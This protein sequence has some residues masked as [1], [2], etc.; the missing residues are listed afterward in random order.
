MITTP[1]AQAK[2]SQKMARVLEM[3]NL[4]VFDTETTGT[5][6]DAQVIEIA[7]VDRFGTTMFDSLVKPTIPVPE[8]ATAIHGI[9]NE[10]LNDAP[11]LPKVEKR[12]RRLFTGKL[13][14]AYNASYDF[15]LLNQSLSACGLQPVTRSRWVDGN[16]SMRFFCIMKVYAEWYGEW[17]DYHGNFRWQALGDAVRQCG[18]SWEGDAH[19]A[20]AD[21]KAA[22]QVIHH[23]AQG[24]PR[25]GGVR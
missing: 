24:K 6:E 23:M 16:T 10:M 9:T 15:R 4:L 19:R 12:L 5:D 22:L 20:L 8:S 13:V 17:N 7:V 11:P 1:E 18:I 2:I 25:G 21:S 14:G 3:D